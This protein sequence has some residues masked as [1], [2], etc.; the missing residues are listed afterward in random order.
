MPDVRFR[1]DA[2]GCTFHTWPQLS[3]LRKQSRKRVEEIHLSLKTLS[4]CRCH[5]MRNSLFPLIEN[6]TRRKSLLQLQDSL[7]DQ[8]T[9]SFCDGN[10]KQQARLLFSSSFGLFTLPKSYCE[11]DIISYQLARAFPLFPRSLKFPRSCVAPHMHSE[12]ICLPQGL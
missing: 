6:A 4:S 5:S 9:P 2:K 11:T 8:L 12:Y 3:R 1:S 10:D 7:S